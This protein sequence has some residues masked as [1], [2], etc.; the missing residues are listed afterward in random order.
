ID[1]GRVT[2]GS[3]T[4]RSFTIFNSGGLPV[5]INI[6]KPPVASE[7]HATTTLAEGESTIEPGQSVTETVRFAP[8]VAG[9]ATDE[10]RI[11]GQDSSGLHEVRFGGEGALPEA[12]GGSV[13]AF[14]TPSFGAFL[15]TAGLLAR[16]GGV[17]HVRL[18]CP[19][20]QGACTGT[21][22]LR[23]ARAIRANA[24]TRRPA[25]VT[26]AAGRFAIP[27]GRSATVSV[28]LTRDARRLLG[29]LRSIPVRLA[30]V[31]TAVSGRAE[32]VHASVVLH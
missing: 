4:T 2:V 31:T 27:A 32:V 26:L 14:K 1:F 16:P 11:A 8:T 20:Q 18:H 24:R 9:A 29:R 3:E 28:F 25:I 12:P 10:W 13:L 23:T 21:L 19:A 6:S 15:T 17:V 7:F 30:T 5:K 22:V